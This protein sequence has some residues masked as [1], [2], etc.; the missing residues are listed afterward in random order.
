MG[1]TTTRNDQIR[2]DT[3]T[4]GSLNDN[5]GIYDETNSYNIDDKVIWNGDVYVAK[6]AVT[7]SAKGDMSNAPNVSSDW[8]SSITL[9]SHLDVSHNGIFP[10]A[11]NISDGGLTLNLAA[12]D[13]PSILMSSTKHTH[14]LVSNSVLKTISNITYGGIMETSANGGLSIVGIR[15]DLGLGVSI[16]SYSQNGDSHIYMNA[17][18]HDGTNDNTLSLPDD[19]TVLGILNNDSIRFK[20]QGNGSVLTSTD[21]AFVNDTNISSGGLVLNQ[22]DDTKPITMLVNSVV[23]HGTTN[24]LAGTIDTSTYGTLSMADTSSGGMRIMGISEDFSSGLELVG[25]NNTGTG[26]ATDGIIC[27]KSIYN[28]NTVPDTRTL[29]SV[30]NLNDTK[31]MVLGN[32]AILTVSNLNKSNISPGGVALNQD[33]ADTPIMLFSSSDV[34]HPLTSASSLGDIDGSTYGG[35]RKIDEDY[36]SLDIVGLNEGTSHAI[37]LNGYSKGMST[38]GVINMD[39]HIHDGSNDSVSNVPV[40]KIVLDIRNNGSVRYMLQGNGSIMTTPNGTVH[41][42]TNISPG[43]L[44]LYQSS[45][46]KPIVLFSSFDIDHGLTSSSNLGSIDTYTYGGFKKTNNDYGGLDIIGITDYGDG[47]SNVPGVMIH[48]IPKE[49]TDGDQYA[50]VVVDGSKHNGSNTKGSLSN[51]DVIFRVRNNGS[52]KFYITGDGHIHAAY[53]TVSTLDVEDDLSLVEATKF[54]M[55]EEV[56]YIENNVTKLVLDPNKYQTP[57]NFKNKKISN[58]HIK[59]VKDLNIIS[60]NGHVDMQQH[61]ALVFGSIT[62]LYNITKVLGA[63]LGFTEEDLK[64]IAMEVN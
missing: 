24:T 48:G 1:T 36:G 54:M 18:A 35:F 31:L 53:T 2:E 22:G 63:K 50:A 20:I 27:L 8:Y 60:N 59:R 25:Y 30:N 17:H 12:N 55:G 57:K 15:S 28:N 46:D 45:E 21:G 51:S 14:P 33:D 23:D 39:A 37:R 5:I 26:L 9:G 43:G 7:P 64:K 13:A 6:A 58:K 44:S 38:M 42:Q 19:D 4:G 61:S 10:N 52:S 32:G 56:D 62:Q 40:N 11:S 29:M 34:V 49:R 41:N 47:T 16:D 3:I